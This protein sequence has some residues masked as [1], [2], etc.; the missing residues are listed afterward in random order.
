MTQF[1]QNNPNM[2]GNMNFGM[3]QQQPQLPVPHNYVLT[4]NFQMGLPHNPT[5]WPNV[6]LSPNMQQQLKLVVGY[7]MK[8]LQDNS[9]K[10]AIRTFTFNLASS[11]NWNNQIMMEMV[12]IV[13][14]Y[15][16]MLMLTQNA[17][18]MQ[19][20]EAAATFI[21]SAYS[22]IMITKFP[23]LQQFVTQ[24]LVPDLQNL[25]NVFGQAVE[26]IRQF[27]QRMTMQQQPQ[28]QQP[29]QFQQ[30]NQ[31]SG[32]APNNGMSFSNNLPAAGVGIVP[33]SGMFSSS[34]SVHT[35]ANSNIP[36]LGMGVSMG[37]M[38]LRNDPPINEI[39]FTPVTIPAQVVVQSD[40]VQGA[41]VKDTYNGL[42]LANVNKH[43]KR[44]WAAANPY[45]F[46][47]NP[48]T[49]TLFYSL[50]PDNTAYEV[51]KSFAEVGMEYA[52]HELDP[53]VQ[54]KNFN[55][56]L[57]ATRRKSA[58]WSAFEDVK[59]AKAIVND[60]ERKVDLP[61]ES[62]VILHE[63]HVAASLEQAI[64]IAKM[65]L[66]NKKIKLGDNSPFEFSYRKVFP[67]YV[68][69]KYLEVMEEMKCKFK[70]VVG[71]SEAYVFLNTHINRIPIEIWKYL[72]DSMTKA[73]N[74]ELNVGVGVSIEI[75]NFHEDFQDLVKSL[76]KREEGVRNAFFINEADVVLSI[77]RNINGE[78]LKQYITLS[79]GVI[80]E[81]SELKHIVFFQD[82]FIVN[83]PWLS[84]AMDI[85]FRERAGAV[86][87]SYFPELFN[88][89]KHVVDKSKSMTIRNRQIITA[90]G[91]IINVDEANF[92]K[93]VYMI[94]RN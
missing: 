15:A 44:K 16:E 68:E 77:F 25:M 53:V 26:Q 2:G 13:S 27:K 29:G 10:N 19:A 28:Y 67:F 30:P 38:G 79:G 76:N 81:N 86:M 24:D 17:P 46:A 59:N 91:V 82:F 60:Q 84:S 74:H 21:V 63:R 58:N 5:S 50:H 52:N 72:N 33:G 31:F 36:D 14:D 34:P 4:P 51:I 61:I 47:Y 69:E 64:A 9:S 62:A 78:S 83:V 49:H 54:D 6:Q 40:S 48:K 87:E 66:E 89:L 57:F 75:D 32:H 37:S 23:A 88:A 42:I 94:S 55:D 56:S 12:S 11:N 39:T 8:E 18:P 73:I 93:D 1:F 65:K 20:L 80:E 3:Q 71:F 43:I 45:S 70:E 92:S 90:D 41:T 7:T 22:A 85:A 35:S